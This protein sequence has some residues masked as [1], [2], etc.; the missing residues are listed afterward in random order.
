M[1]KHL[2]FFGKLDFREIKM[3]YIIICKCVVVSTKNALELI[4]II[5]SNKKGKKRLGCVHLIAIEPSES[6]FVSL[7]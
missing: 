6:H 4:C 7:A 1:F 3:F 5:F 2:S